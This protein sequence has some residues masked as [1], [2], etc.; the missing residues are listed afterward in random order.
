MSDNKYVAKQVSNT[1]SAQTKTSSKKNI[2]VIA[3]CACLTVVAVVAIGIT[4]YIV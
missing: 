2:A 1:S 3:G 4:I